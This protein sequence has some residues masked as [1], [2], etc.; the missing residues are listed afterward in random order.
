MKRKATRLK[1]RYAAT[2]KVEYDQFYPR[3]SKPLIDAHSP[4]ARSTRQ[5]CA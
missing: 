4:D 2:G 1:A 5:R 3:N